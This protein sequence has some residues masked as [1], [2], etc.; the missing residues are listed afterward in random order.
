VARAFRRG[1]VVCCASSSMSY[2][3]LIHITTAIITTTTKH[4]SLEAKVVKCSCA[5]TLLHDKFFEY[6]Q[7]YRDQEDSRYRRTSPLP[8]AVKPKMADDIEAELMLAGK[9]LDKA[10]LIK[11]YTAYHTNSNPGRR[12]RE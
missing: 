8:L 2:N 3:S 1:G 9:E 11:Q 5:T 7:A 12:N 10:S 6:S 4:H